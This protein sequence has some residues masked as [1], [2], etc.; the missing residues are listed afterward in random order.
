MSRPELNTMLAIV[1]PIIAGFL[2]WLVQRKINAKAETELKRVAELAEEKAKGAEERR[3]RLAADHALVLNRLAKLEAQGSTDS[4]TLALLKQEM[5]PMAEAMKRKLVDILTHPGKEF[6]K[7]DELLAKVRE[8]GAP[9]PP[10]LLPLLKERVTSESEHVTEQERL[11]AQALPIIV[12]LA[13]LEA[14]EAEDV[15]I[16]GIQLVSS[17]AKS[18][19]TKKEEEGQ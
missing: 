7:P 17:T 11:A 3:E 2:V 10:E 13:E 15:T 16:T 1:V 6:A 12:R 9:M 4:Q 14:K 19:E 5:L 18:P 8:V